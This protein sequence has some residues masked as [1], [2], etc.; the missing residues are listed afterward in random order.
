MRSPETIALAKEVVHWH[1]FSDKTSDP[2]PGNMSIEEAESILADTDREVASAPKVTLGVFYFPADPSHSRMGTHLSYMVGM[3]VSGACYWLAPGEWV[4]DHAEPNHF[5]GIQPL[6][7]AFVRSPDIDNSYPIRRLL[8]GRSYD[9]F[10]LGD[11]VDAGMGN[12]GFALGLRQ[13]PV[14]CPEGITEG[15]TE[16][17]SQ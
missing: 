10:S 3:D 8:S 17:V 6:P 9:D 13:C 15:V 12:W 4:P 16:G 14:V 7:Y 11:R 2:K 1:L 5:A